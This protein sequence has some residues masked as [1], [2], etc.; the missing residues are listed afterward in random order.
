MLFKRFVFINFMLL[1]PSLLVNLPPSSY[2]TTSLLLQTTI[3][4]SISFNREHNKT[5]KQVATLSKLFKVLLLL[6]RCPQPLPFLQ[7]SPLSSFLFRSPFEVP[8]HQ[9]IHSL[10]YHLG[11]YHGRYAVRQGQR[12]SQQSKHVSG[13]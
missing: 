3:K 11:Y 8:L 10:T 12:P 1:K 2:S 7:L 9:F 4:K 13:W 6:L 5:K